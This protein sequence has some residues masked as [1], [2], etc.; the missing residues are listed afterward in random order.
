M[1]VIG[2][3]IRRVPAKRFIEFYESVIKDSRKRSSA[4][5]RE[6][7]KTPKKKQSTGKPKKRS[8]GGYG[9]AE[10]GKTMP[11]HRFREVRRDSP[12]PTARS[13][14]IFRALWKTS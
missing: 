14:P 9:L 3:A 11:N 2:E 6:K 1:D 8:G 12:L 10:G 4:S 13:V 7:T 5:S